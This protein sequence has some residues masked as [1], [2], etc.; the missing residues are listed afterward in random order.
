MS[1]TGVIE[2]IYIIKLRP[3]PSRTKSWSNYH[4]FELDIDNVANDDSL[5]KETN[6]HSQHIYKGSDVF[7]ISGLLNT[8]LQSVI[9]ER[10]HY[11]C[12][13]LIYGSQF[14]SSQV[15]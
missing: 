15:P 14:A 12:H 8:I 13:K 11:S 7:D 2:A 1:G 10:R 3:S 6:A 9:T 5:S 4:V